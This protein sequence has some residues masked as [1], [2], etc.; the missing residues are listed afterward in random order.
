ME[1]SGILWLDDESIPV[2]P[3]DIIIIPPHVY[4]WIDNTMNQADFKLFTLWGRQEENETY[5][6]RKNAWGTSMKYV[7]EA[8]LEKRMGQK[9]CE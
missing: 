2:K 5:F 7:D 4:H 1:G 8:Y 6:V 9:E 3:G